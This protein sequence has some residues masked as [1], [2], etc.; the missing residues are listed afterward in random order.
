MVLWPSRLV[1]Y[2]PPAR[3]RAA[4]PGQDQEMELEAC[5]FAVLCCAV[6]CWCVAVACTKAGSTVVRFGRSG[7][8]THA[9]GQA[10][11]CS[12]AW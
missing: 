8:E 3:F 4:G 5:A 12:S 2:L 1:G 6:Q 10:V 7:S 9:Q 11:N